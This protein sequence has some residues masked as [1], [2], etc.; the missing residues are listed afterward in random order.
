M[1]KNQSAR[2]KWKWWTLYFLQSI[3]FFESVHLNTSGTEHFM[4]SPRELTPNLVVLVPFETWRLLR[5]NYGSYWRSLTATKENKTPN[6]LPLPKNTFNYHPSKFHE[7]LGPMGVSIFSRK[8]HSQPRCSVWSC[9]AYLKRT[10][11]PTSWGFSFDLLT[12]PVAVC[13]LQKTKIP[14]N[15][16]LTDEHFYCSHVTKA[17]SAQSQRN[18]AAVWT[19][20]LIHTPLVTHTLIDH[21][22]SSRPHG[23]TDNPHAASRSF[24]YCAS[25]SANSKEP[26]KKT[27]RKKIESLPSAGA[28]GP[29]WRPAPVG[30][31]AAGSA[32]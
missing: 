20:F 28:R 6:L 32:R 21:R 16:R 29:C 17:Q 25:S 23:A 27:D 4:M 30:P 11:N 2:R 26:R 7:D 18:N 15:S 24:A 3:C 9:F 31:A 14:Q 13:P 8:H 5:A 12:S 19:R 1:I 10:W 22:L